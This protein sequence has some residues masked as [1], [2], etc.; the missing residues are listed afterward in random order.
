MTG[1]RESYLTLCRAGFGSLEFWMSLPVS[2]LP[3]WLKVVDK[4]VKRRK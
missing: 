2:S 3:N 4:L 1:L